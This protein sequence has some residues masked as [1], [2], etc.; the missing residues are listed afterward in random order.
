MGNGLQSHLEGAPLGLLIFEG[1]LCGFLPLRQPWLP[2]GRAH[3][4]VDDVGVVVSLWG[5]LLYFGH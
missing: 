5:A 2:V 1:D 4:Q 3:P